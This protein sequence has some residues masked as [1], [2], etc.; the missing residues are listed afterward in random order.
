MQMPLWDHLDEL[1]SRLIKVAA[2][3]ALATLFSFWGADWMLAW[4]LNPYPNA[5][6]T[7]TSLQPAGVFIQSMRL[8]LICGVIL[9]LP[10]LLYQIWAFV[11][12][13]LSK[14]ERKVVVISLYA[15]TLLFAV[16]IAFAYY[17]VIPK[18]LGFFWDYSRH[19][20][21]QPSWT[22]DNYLNF[23]LMFLLSFGIA[24]EL[25]LV[26]LLLVHFKILSLETVSEKR[27]YI[28]VVLA[29]IAAILTPPDVV[30]LIMLFIPLWLLFEISVRIAKLLDRRQKTED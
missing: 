1:R 11:S 20:G 24:F 26:M 9:T 16:G 28:I 29:I 18:A 8:A 17:L 21:I 14:D 27:P 15:G 13:G 3:V 12:P 30:S 2:A 4:L 5:T 10:I 25:P 6:Q 7:L 23:I 22:I 19:F